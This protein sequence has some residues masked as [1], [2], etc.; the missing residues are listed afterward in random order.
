MQQSVA[1]FSDGNQNQ[2]L[3]LAMDCKFPSLNLATDCKFSSLSLARSFLPTEFFFVANPSLKDLA[4][5]FL[6]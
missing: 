2:S 5:D 4:T 1:K 6:I 3:N